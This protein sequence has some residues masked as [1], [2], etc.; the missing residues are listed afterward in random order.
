MLTGRLCV[1]SFSAAL[2]Y[3]RCTLIATR[4]I[5]PTSHRRFHHSTL[6]AVHSCGFASQA[7]HGLPSNL[8]YQVTTCATCK[9][10]FAYDQI[11]RQEHKTSESTN[12]TLAKKDTAFHMQDIEMQQSK[13]LVFAHTTVWPSKFSVVASP[14][15]DENVED[16]PQRLA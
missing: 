8:C 16:T 9:G 3:E 7:S 5:G 11:H 4:L 10:F 14:L 12:S 2:R 13:T 15:A 1:A 6:G